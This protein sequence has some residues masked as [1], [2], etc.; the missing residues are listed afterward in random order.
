M[1]LGVDKAMSH[2]AVKHVANLGVGSTG[3]LLNA[4][5]GQSR[6]AADQYSENIAFDG[7]RERT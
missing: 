4:S 6:A 1:P 5:T 3:E 7:R 2:E